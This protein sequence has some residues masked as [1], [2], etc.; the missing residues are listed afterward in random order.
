M[1]ILS[2]VIGLVVGGLAVAIAIETTGR[3]RDKP[4]PLGKLT[5]SWRLSELHAPVIVASDVMDVDVPATARIAASGLV[6]PAVQDRCDVRQVP[7]VRAEFALDLA[8]GRG[9][10]FLGGVR[11][12]AMALL[13]VDPATVQ[14]LESEFRTLWDRSDPY[15]ERLRIADLAGR[16]GVTVEVDGVVRDVLPWQDRFMIRLEDQGS[17][18]GVTVEKDASE[19]VDERIRVQGRLEK[20]KTGYPVIAARDIRRVR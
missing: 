20:D 6:E 1:D 12:D 16:Q 18:I 13:T 4:Q 15:V 19:L 7:P 3:N 5:T 2:L 17:I 9:L 8:A 11:R 14:R 10:L